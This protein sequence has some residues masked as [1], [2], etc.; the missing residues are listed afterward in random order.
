[1]GNWNP[2]TI[3]IAGGPMLQGKKKYVLGAPIDPRFVLIATAAEWPDLSVYG[4]LIDTPRHH[5]ARCER[6]W[7]IAWGL[8]SDNSE[9]VE[10]ERQR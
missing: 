6:S 3:G 4:P 2:A 7:E 8:P 5:F 10:G 9:S 1:M